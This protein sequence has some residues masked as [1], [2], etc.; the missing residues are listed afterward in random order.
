MKAKSLIQTNPYL[1]DR[2]IREKLIERS[3][4]SSSGVEGIKVD[5]KKKSNIQILNRRDKKIY[6]KIRIK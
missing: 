4:I 5:F 3:V 6:N 1:K 2:K